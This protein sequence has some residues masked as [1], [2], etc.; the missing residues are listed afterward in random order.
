MGDSVF[1]YL[2]SAPPQGAGVTL[3]FK[4]TMGHSMSHNE[5][6]RRLL[7]GQGVP[8]LSIH[9][10]LALLRWMIVGRVLL[11]TFLFYFLDPPKKNTYE[12]RVVGDRVCQRLQ[13]ARI[14]ESQGTKFLSRP[15]LTET[16]THVQTR[17]RTHALRRA[18]TGS[19][20]GWQETG[21][22]NHGK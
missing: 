21:T 22:R 17:K 18:G 1:T 2:L 9:L 10:H 14:V 13:W 12:D 5:Q 16:I 15:N 11:Y 8:G 6:V 7:A 3:G 20:K 19:K 4:A